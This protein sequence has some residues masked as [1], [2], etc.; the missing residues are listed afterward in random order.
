MLCNS[1]LDP[2]ATNWSKEM[3]YLIPAESLFLITVICKYP[4]YAQKHVPTI[5]KIVSTL[6]NQTI[7]MEN[8]ALKISSA[9]F[10]KISAGYDKAAFLGAVLVG[11]FTSLHFYRNNTKSKVIPT[12]I[13]K[14]VHSFFANFMASHSTAELVTACDKI[15]QGILFM[16]LKSEGRQIKYVNE[17]AR[18]K[19]YAI[20]AY[21]RLLAETALVAPPE[22]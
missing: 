22:T 20:V 15:Q 4:E 19:K 10:E 6:M 5:Q 9:V 1:I 16:V 2:N 11:I 14:A 12:S 17:P 7:R 13:I 18:D 3:K 21:S 8:E